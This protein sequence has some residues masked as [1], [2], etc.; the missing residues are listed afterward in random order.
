MSVETNE[1]PRTGLIP[2]PDDYVG[3]GDRVDIFIGDQSNTFIDEFYVLTANELLGSP[4]TGVQV[5]G[6]N[7]PYFG[8]SQL[9]ATITKKI[10]VSGIVGGTGVVLYHP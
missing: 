5:T 8:F 6:S 9:D 1:T 2:V 10:E 4:V 7:T 3:V